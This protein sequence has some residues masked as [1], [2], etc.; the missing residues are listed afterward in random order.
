MHGARGRLDYREQLR[1]EVPSERDE[2]VSRK[3]CPGGWRV[4]ER[5][6]LKPV[7]FERRSAMLCLSF[8]RRYES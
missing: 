3:Q 5:L 6:A 2:P 8:W 1:P 7:P 4:E